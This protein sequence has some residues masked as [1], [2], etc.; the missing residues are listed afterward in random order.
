MSGACHLIYFDTLRQVDGM[1]Q[2]RIHAIL[3]DGRRFEGDILIGADGIWS[4]VHGGQ[5]LGHGPLTQIWASLLKPAM[6]MGCS[7]VCRC[8]ASWWARRR[9]R[10]ANT[11]AT[12]ASR[13]SRRRTSTLLAT[14]CSWA[15][16]STLCPQMSAAARCSGARALLAMGDQWLPSRCLVQVVVNCSDKQPLTPCRYGFHKEPAGGEDPPNGKKARLLQIFGHWTD[17]VTD[18][19][20][21]TPEEDVIRRDIYDRPPI[22]KWTQVAAHVEWT[23]LYPWT[24]SPAHQ[25]RRLPT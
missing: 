3:E 8:G 16:A 21:A 11:P 13:T 19:I 7:T 20:R 10:T 25:Q 15:T 4:K 17:M 14:A 6:L 12:R 23:L 2:K 22:F 5:E 1:G 9:R 24:F 18:L